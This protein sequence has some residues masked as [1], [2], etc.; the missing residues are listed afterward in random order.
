MVRIAGT[1]RAGFDAVASLPAFIPQTF[2]TALFDVGL[3]D[4]PLDA[5]GR[6]QTIH[7]IDQRV[8]LIMTVQL[9][10]FTPGGKAGN[11]LRSIKRLNPETITSI[12][13]DKINL[14]L[15][16]LIGSGDIVVTAIDCTSNSLGQMYVALSYTNM[17]LPNPITATLPVLF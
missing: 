16:P 9:G 8:A 5:S 4:Y 10:S 7:P 17:R 14:A 13:T 15:A 1:G 12:V 11:G 6:V 2:E 3:K